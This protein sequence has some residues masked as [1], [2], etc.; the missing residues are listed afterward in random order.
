LAS[1]LKKLVCKVFKEKGLNPPSDNDGVLTFIS[2]LSDGTKGTL[3]LSEA[4]DGY[5][6]VW[7]SNALQTML[8]IDELAWLRA[9]NR[10]DLVGMAGEVE[11]LHYGMA[12]LRIRPRDGAELTRDLLTFLTRLGMA[13]EDF[14][15]AVSASPTGTSPG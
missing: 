2:M 14:R 3:H 1:N 4:D 11:G 13:V 7:C 6:T 15:K 10:H 12:S 8:P 9:A 5:S